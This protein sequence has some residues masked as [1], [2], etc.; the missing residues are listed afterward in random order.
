MFNPLAQIAECA[1]ELNAGLL[2]ALHKQSLLSC[3]ISW[4][5]ICQIPR[6]AWTKVN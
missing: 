5:I 6:D 4:E 2:A 1:K 3:Y